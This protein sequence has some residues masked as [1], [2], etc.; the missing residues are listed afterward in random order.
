VSQRSGMTRGDKRRNRRLE[1]LRR[2]VPRENALVGVDLAEDKQALAVTDHDSR[3][4][5]RMTVRAILAHQLGGGL[6]W[7]V[8]QARRAGFAGVTVAC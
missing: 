3:V 2:L 1:E 6:D 5:A 7:A 4:L 8:G